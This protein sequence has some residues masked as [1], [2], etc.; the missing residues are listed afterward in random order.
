MLLRKKQDRVKPVI[1]MTA[2]EWIADRLRRG[3]PI[4]LK[5]D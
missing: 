4:E 3:E 2:Q 5:Y 1:A